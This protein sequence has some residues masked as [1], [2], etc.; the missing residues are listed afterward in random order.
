MAQPRDLTDGVVVLSSGFLV[1]RAF[2]I[3]WSLALRAWSFTG[4]C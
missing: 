2:L 1:I 3:D 4:N